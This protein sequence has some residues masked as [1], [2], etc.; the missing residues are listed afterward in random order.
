MYS[1]LNE[2]KSVVA[3]RFIRILKN[4]IYKYMTSMSKDVYID[5]LDII[6]KYNNTNHSIIKMKPV[7]VT[8]ITMIKILNL[9]LLMLLK[10]QNIKT[11]LQKT[12]L[13]IDKKF[14]RLKKLK[15][16]YCGHFLLVI[17]TEKKLL[18]RFP[19]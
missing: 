2:G 19:K 4:N 7:D 3:E 17:L 16:L 14:L 1:T 18:E 8:S 6:N 10:Y 5:K 15:T 12:M 9:K 13:Q 11:F